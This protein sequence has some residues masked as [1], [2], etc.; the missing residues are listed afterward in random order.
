MPLVILHAHGCNFRSLR[1]LWKTAVPILESYFF[2]WHP[3]HDPGGVQ[4]SLFIVAGFSKHIF[5][6]MVPPISQKFSHRGRLWHCGI[7]WDKSACVCVSDCLIFV[8]CPV[9]QFDSLLV[10]LQSTVQ[11]LWN[12]PEFNMTSVAEKMYYTEMYN[13]RSCLKPTK[14]SLTDTFALQIQHNTTG[15]H[16]P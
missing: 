3:G 1:L 16:F 15:P 5:T 10:W 8:I 4:L 2:P 14:E 13:N 7:L 11:D 6:V 9:W 12:S